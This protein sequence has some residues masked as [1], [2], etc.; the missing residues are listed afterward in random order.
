MDHVHDDIENI[1]M[2]YAITHQPYM[3]RGGQPYM[4]GHQTE[5]EQKH[6]MSEREKETIE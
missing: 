3:K 1:H 6:K 4:H 2:K 5:R